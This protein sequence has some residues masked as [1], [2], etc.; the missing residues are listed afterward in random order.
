MELKADVVN[1]SGDKISTVTLNK[2]V[3]FSES[4][5]NI[6]HRVVKT[7]LASRRLGTASTKTR[8]EVRGGGR[9]P[10][11]QKGTGRARAGSIRSPIWRGGGVTFGP[12]PRDYSM[13]LPKKI[14]YEAR[15]LALYMK[16]KD[17]KILVA[18]DFN[19]KE[20]STKNATKFLKSL[21]DENKNLVILEKDKE[22]VEKSFRNIP[23]VNVVGVD[24]LSVY[25]I[26]NAER[27][28]FTK[29]SL[30]ETVEVY[31]R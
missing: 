4:D 18:E 16:A 24:R 11:R 2:K 14:R 20:P 30:E 26:L 25:D 27:L 22:I 23:T 31:G 5:V 3:F 13:R 17:K 28:I 7:Y 8:D 21:G 15:K 6:L 12:K 1:I 19:F 10:W 9:K 29:K